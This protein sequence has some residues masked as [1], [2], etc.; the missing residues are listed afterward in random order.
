MLDSKTLRQII[1][2]IYQ[3]DDDFIVPIS[4]NWFVPEVK[5]DEKPGT[6]IGYRIVSKK[7]YFS[8]SEADE[9]KVS[10]RLTFIGENA[11]KLADNVHFWKDMKEVQKVFL[12]YK[13]QLNYSDCVSFTYPLKNDKSEMSWIIDM[14]CYSDYI[15]D[16]KLI[17]SDTKRLSILKKL[18]TKRQSNE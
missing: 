15:Q 12:K 11:E 1:K 3:L 6:Y 18:I 4:S 14:S 9:L 7:N 13:I 17:K 10:F 16:L 8:T 2:E 5:L